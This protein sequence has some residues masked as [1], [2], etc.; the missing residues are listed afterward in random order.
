MEKSYTEALEILKNSEVLYSKEKIEQRVTEMAKDISNDI[1]NDI[2]VFLNVMNGSVFF[3]AEL[4][5]RIE[6]PFFLDYVHATRY[7]NT[8]VGKREVQWLHKPDLKIIQNKN[9]YIIDDILDEGHTL[10]EIKNFILSS[11]AKSCKIVVLINKEI[12][13]LKPVEAD[14]IGFTSPNKYLFGV[15]MDVYGLYRQ[16]PDLL[17]ML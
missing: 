8:T 2:P 15:G 4:L 12:N 13:V 10:H 3:S 14:Y 16:L 17:I 11:G 1:D 9:V 6:K 7:N 5:K